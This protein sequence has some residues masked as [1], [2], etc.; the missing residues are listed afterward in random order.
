LVKETLKIIGGAGPGA[1]GPAGYCWTHLTPPSVVAAIPPPLTQ[2]R[3]ASR[4]LTDHTG[5]APAGVGTPIQVAAASE[6]SKTSAPALLNVRVAR[7]RRAVG[8]ASA[9][10]GEPEEKGRRC[11]LAPEFVV[12]RTAEA[13]VELTATKHVVA[14]GQ[15]TAVARDH[16][17]STACNDQ[18][19][20]PLPENRTKAEV[21][22]PTAQQSSDPGAQVI[23]WTDPAPAG[24]FAGC[25]PAP[26]DASAG[27][28]ALREAA[29]AA[30]A[31]AARTRCGTRNT[32]RQDRRETGRRRAGIA[33]TAAARDRSESCLPR[34]R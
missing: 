29:I 16:P 24:R 27:V 17:S 28:K 23:A 7:H 22:P 8:Q 12:T 18:V 13:D 1:G 9:P 11:H 33:F 2:H 3:K 5:E 34:Y 31:T 21:V 32:F 30:V 19:C 25:K 10:T 26:L 14:F 20:P 4:Q 15:E 6:D